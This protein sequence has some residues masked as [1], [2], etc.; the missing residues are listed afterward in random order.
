MTRRSV[1]LGLPACAVAQTRQEKGRAV[2][3]A[4]LEAL[5]GD[6]FLAMKDRTETGRL[7]SFY[8]ERL[9]GLAVATIS[10]RYVSAP[11]V[12]EAGVVWQ[13]ERQAFG[14][15]KEEWAVLFDERKGWE[16]TFRGARPTPTATL[17]RYQETTRRNVLYT[18]RQRGNEKG[19]TVEPVGTEIFDNQPMDVI[20]ILD[21]T[22]TVV[23]V[24]VHQSTHLPM[25]QMFVRRDAARDRFDEET[26]FGKYRDVG[27][28]VQWPYSITRS[29]NG[30]RIFQMFSES[31]TI[32]DGLTDELF[33]IS[34]K[35]KILEEGK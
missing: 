31:V 1:L 10:T 5:G 16:I 26:L 11:D 9:R 12:P 7:Y 22:T 2:F 25:K 24:W 13:R 27:G 15:K 34:A 30:E 28:G 8:R 35:T 6:R 29:R 21:S 23:R 32:N 33:T 3:D 20:E 14:K 4:M 19:L 17:E 18:L